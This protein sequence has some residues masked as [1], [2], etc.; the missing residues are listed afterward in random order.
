MNIHCSIVSNITQDLAPSWGSCVE[1]KRSS[2][3]VPAHQRVL[4][5]KTIP[6]IESNILM[7]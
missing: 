1:M 6:E 4:L 7:L 2:E 5:Y 3:S